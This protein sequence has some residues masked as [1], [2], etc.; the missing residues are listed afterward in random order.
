MYIYCV[1]V[2]NNWLFLKFLNFFKKITIRLMLF[3]FRVTI[4]ILYAVSKRCE[5]MAS[6]IDNKT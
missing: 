5:Q 6:I 3:D 1:I 2:I 4:Q